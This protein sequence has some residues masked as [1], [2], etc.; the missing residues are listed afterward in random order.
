MA[1]FHPLASGFATQAP[2]KKDPPRNFTNTI[3][4]KFV[5][6]P[7]GSFVMGSPREEL[8]PEKILGNLTEFQLNES[9]HRG[10]L[11]KGFYRAAY[12]VT[13]EQWKEVM[14]NNP[15]HF[16]GDKDLPVESV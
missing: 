4:M 15:S 13:Q 1:R 10:T 5:W 9:Q 3:G 14:G 6:I 12:T 7:P 11:A 16:K 2:E 8:G